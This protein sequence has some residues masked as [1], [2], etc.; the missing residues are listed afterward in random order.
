M[1]LIVVLHYIPY[2]LD[3][4]DGLKDFADLLLGQV[5][6]EVEPDQLSPHAFG[7]PE[8]ANNGRPTP[9]S[10]RGRRSGAGPRAHG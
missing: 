3:A 7:R 9:T 5:R 8:F 6:R 10:L 1:A 4:S 2:R